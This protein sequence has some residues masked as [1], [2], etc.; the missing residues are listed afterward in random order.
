MRR[1][2]PVL[3]LVLFVSSLMVLPA[4][5][6]A[7][8]QE[9][10]PAASAADTGAMVMGGVMFTPL[11]MA[12]GVAL[13]AMADLEVARVEFAPGAGFPFDASEPAGVL[14]IVESGAL[15]LQVEE[16]GWMISRGRALAEALAESPIDPDVSGVLEPVAQGAEGTL[17][18]GDVAQI[19]GYLT[20]SVTNQGDAPASALL[21]LFVPGEMEA[22]ATPAS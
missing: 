18:A 17:Q 12:P 3:A 20:G 11:G 22:E 13:P 4:T 16:Q 8:A 15:T 6:P 7:S 10:T 1:L 5:T 21:V 19:P 2:I 9:A 14:I